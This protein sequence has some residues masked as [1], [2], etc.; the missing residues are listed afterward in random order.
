[1]LSVRQVPR[2]SSSYKI[3]AK[4]QCNTGATKRSLNNTNYPILDDL[5]VIFGNDF[6]VHRTREVLSFKLYFAEFLLNMFPDCALSDKL[7]THLALLWE[8]KS[9]KTELNRKLTFTIYWMQNAFRIH[10]RKYGYAHETKG[11]QW[12]RLVQ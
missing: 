6:L 9:M 11:Y 1:M 12:I 7:R 2:Q 10:K 4:E 5:E 3:R 8:N